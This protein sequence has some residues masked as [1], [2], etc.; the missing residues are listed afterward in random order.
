MPG[1]ATQ[2]VNW[3]REPPVTHINGCDPQASPK[4]IS[5][6]TVG[7]QET[8]SRPEP[9]RCVD[10]RAEIPSARQSDETRTQL[11]YSHVHLIEACHLRREPSV[12]DIS[13]G[14]TERALES[15]S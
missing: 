8:G 14:A 11:R 3:E 12:K 5:S 9:D 10:P 7:K 6:R 15:G 4:S 2:P 13:L 1:P